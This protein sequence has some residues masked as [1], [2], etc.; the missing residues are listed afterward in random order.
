MTFCYL[1]DDIIFEIASYLSTYGTRKLISVNEEM[2]NSKI[3]DITKYNT[4]EDH[5]GKDWRPGRN[6]WIQGIKS[7]KDKMLCEIGE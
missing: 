5:T 3:A 1:P 2:S 6:I 4:G 7:N